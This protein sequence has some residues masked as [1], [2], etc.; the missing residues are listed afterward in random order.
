MKDQK[1]VLLICQLS[2]KMHMTRKFVF[3]S[4]KE[5]SKSRKI[6]VNRFLISPLVPEL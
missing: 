2:L 5:T 4:Y 1:L 3:F 6:A